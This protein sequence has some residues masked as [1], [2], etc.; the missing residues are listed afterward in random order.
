[1]AAAIVALVVLLLAHSAG[2]APIS[3]AADNPVALNS[4]VRVLVHDVRRSVVQVVVTGYQPAADGAATVLAHSRAIGSGA[5]IA[6]GGF[7]VTNAHVVAGAERI[8]VVLADADGDDTP[9]GHRGRTVGARLVGAAEELDL[10]LLQVDADL[11]VLRI[12]AP[13]T[14]HQGDLV[15]AFGS[16]E[17]LRDSVSMGLVSAVARQVRPDSPIAYVQTDSAINPGNSGGPLVNM[18][19]ELVGL[20]T[21]IHTQSGGSEGL[22]FA[23]PGSIVALAY[24][25]LREHGHLHR[26]A[27][28][29]A[30]QD[31]TPAMKEGLGL[32]VDSGLIVAD[33]FDGGPAAAAGMRPGDVIVSLDGRPLAS[34][35]FLELYRYLYALADGQTVKLG[36]LRG[37]RAEAVS[38][39]A[40]VPPHECGP[41][42][43]LAHI[44][45]NL[46][47]PLGI[48]ATT[49]DDDER[50]GVVVVARLA[51]PAGGDIP[52]AMGDVVRAINGEPATSAAALRDAMGR[53][54]HGHGVVLQVER[55]GQLTYVAFER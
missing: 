45:E 13:E 34:L 48:V 16:P 53:I 18:H 42:L 43:T 2:A 24:P 5:V 28:G 1:M 9:L 47:E 12:A 39:T 50:S 35:S 52:L 31:I 14:I 19:G 8:D 17:G 20:N 54:P 23:L 41:P 11:P 44:D 29:I 30:L 27:L 22:G 33:V 40:I 25:Q 49:L 10:A 4:A 15:F 21:F 38:L 32:P 46:V 3:G 6:A 36:Y 7:I 55:G 26:A 37:D 51:G